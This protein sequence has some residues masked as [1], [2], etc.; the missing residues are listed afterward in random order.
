M[1]PIAKDFYRRAITPMKNKP[2]F[3]S[4]L[5]EVFE[6]EIDPASIL[7]DL[8]YECAHP[9]EID[10]W[11]T[12]DY[13]DYER[14]ANSVRPCE[15]FLLGNRSKGALMPRLVCVLVGTLDE[16]FSFYFLNEFVPESS[17]SLSDPISWSVDFKTESERLSAIQESKEWVNHVSERDRLILLKIIDVGLKH[18]GSIRNDPTI[19]VNPHFEQESFME[20]LHNLRKQLA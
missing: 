13:T 12:V 6:V 20:G 8:D 18:I 16:T 9:P 14:F 5:D 2:D 10:E 19:Q 3:A 1:I 4:L 17:I 15:L 7:S 11:K